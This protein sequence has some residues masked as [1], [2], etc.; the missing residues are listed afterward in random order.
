MH[1]VEFDTLNQM[2]CVFGFLDENINKVK[3]AFNVAIE[4]KDACGPNIGHLTITSEDDEAEKRAAEAIE[5]LKVLY[6]QE[7]GLP[8]QKVNY[9]IDLAGEGETRDVV[10]AMND[11]IV[12]TFLGKP[13]RCRTAGQ[14]QFV[15]AM[16]KNTITLCIGPAGTG[17]TYLAAAMAAKLLKEKAVDRIVMTRPAVESGENLGFLPGDL[18]NKVDPYLR[19]LHDA[20][21]DIFGAEAYK[22]KQED[23]VIEVAPIAYMRGRTINRA[24]YII[25]ECQNMT[26]ASLKMAL[27]RIGEGSVM[28]L[29]GDITQIDLPAGQSGLKKC[30]DI[31]KGI[32]GISV[33]H[34][35]KKDV[36]RHKIVRDIVRAF[37]IHEEDESKKQQRRSYPMKR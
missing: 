11:D 7:K 1:T 27:T 18:M 12:T 29:N 30:A 36:V 16:K 21:F 31:L 20:M 28:V 14:K 33:I 4:L 37:E 2:Q 9:A 35:T 19:P 22:K 25:D 26:L 32:E 34:L 17:K 24:C 6:E 15:E 3:N 5:T 13:I 10:R 23:N 8:E